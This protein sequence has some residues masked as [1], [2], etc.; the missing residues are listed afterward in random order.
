MKRCLDYCKMLKKTERK[1]N[2][3]YWEK[4]R[5]LKAVGLDKKNK[6]FERAL[7]TKDFSDFIEEEEHKEE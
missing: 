6:R 3:Y 7:R 2:D 4:E 1:N 5:R